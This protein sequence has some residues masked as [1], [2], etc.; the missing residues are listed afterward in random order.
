MRIVR[1]RPEHMAALR[2]QPAQT[3]FSQYLNDL[4]YGRALANEWTF[5]ALDKD[6]VIGCGGAVEMWAGRAVLWSLLAE[7]AGRHFVSI[8]RAVSGFL[9]ACPWRRVEASVDCEFE[10]GQRWI[11]LLGFQHEGRMRGY[12]PDGRD[13]DLFARVRHG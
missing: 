9:S 4:E 5:T 2:L 6:R 8:H 10:A 13:Q 3:G 1:F 11:R 12:T 7:D